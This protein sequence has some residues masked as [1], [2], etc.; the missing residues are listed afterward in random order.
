MR[1]YKEGSRPWVK[2]P[3][4]ALQ[5]TGLTRS[6]CLV[7]AL[8]I[9]DCGTNAATVCTVD[10]IASAGSIGARTVRRSLSA[11]RRRGYIS[12][13]QTGRGIRVQLLAAA[14]QLLPA[15][16][17]QQTNATRSSDRCRS[18]SRSSDRCT[19]PDPEIEQYAELVNRFR[20]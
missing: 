2:L 11:L 3:L 4:R 20:E 14:V 18:R 6:D 7:L 8:L 15:A 10:E 9:D 5:D 1:K 16:D 12:T 17:Q 13:T 19:A